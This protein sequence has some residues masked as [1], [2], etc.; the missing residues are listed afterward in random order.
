MSE[1][2]VSLANAKAHLS[3]LAERAAAGESILI[4]KR[5]K[6]VVRL[7]SATATKKP[8]DTNALRAVT[9]TQ[10]SSVDETFIRRIRDDA[11][12]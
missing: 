6:A 1:P 7:S 5:G 10:S 4:T 3:E 9:D 11:R 12:Y 8:I 2:T